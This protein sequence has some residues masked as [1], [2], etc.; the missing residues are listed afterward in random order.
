MTALSGVGLPPVFFTTVA[1]FAVVAFAVVARDAA[2]ADRAA[3]TGRRMGAEPSVMTVTPASAS[4][5]LICLA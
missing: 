1:A 4:A 5:C 2:V 3:D